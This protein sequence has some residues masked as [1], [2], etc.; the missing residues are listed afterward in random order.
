MRERERERCAQLVSVTVNPCQAM[1]VVAASEIPALVFTLIICTE[2]W[3]NL[4][5][6]FFCIY[7]FTLLLVLHH[8]CIQIMWITH[9]LCISQMNFGECNETHQKTENSG[10]DCFCNSLYLIYLSAL[11]AIFHDND[12]M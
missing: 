4:V 8:L 5:T 7:T 2:V 3:T 9:I 10:A 12:S 1:A 6:N 11:F